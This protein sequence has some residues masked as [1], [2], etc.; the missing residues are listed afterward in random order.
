[1]LFGILLGLY[2]ARIPMYYFLFGGNSKFKR[3]EISIGI[4]IGARV[5]TSVEI[6]LAGFLCVLL[7]V[8]GS[9]ALENDRKKLNKSFHIS[10]LIK[11]KISSNYA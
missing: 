4:F 9:E 1:L 6:L 7:H 3:E 5:V 10:F 8:F 2:E 11:L